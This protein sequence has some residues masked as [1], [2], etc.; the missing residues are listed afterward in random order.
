MPRSFRSARQ[1]HGYRAEDFIRIG[2]SEPSFRGGPIYPSHW[3]SGY[4][5]KRDL[6][7]VERLPRNAIVYWPEGTDIGG[8]GYDPQDPCCLLA[9][10]QH[11][12]KFDYSASAE[13]A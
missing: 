4:W 9:D 3:Y 6:A 8:D 1:Y 7:F 5:R 10:I 11:W 2:K 13:A 12:M